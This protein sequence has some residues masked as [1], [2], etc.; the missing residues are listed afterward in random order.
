MH[1]RVY[2]WIKE[3]FPHEGHRFVNG[4]IP[5]ASESEFIPQTWLKRELIGRIYV[6]LLVATDLFAF[7]FPEQI[8]E[9]SDLV[10]VEF[11][12]VSP[13]SPELSANHF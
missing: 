11:G 8:P 7:C 13:S 1:Y 12:K 3:K 9:E 5:G 10:L 6:V 2:E 4:A